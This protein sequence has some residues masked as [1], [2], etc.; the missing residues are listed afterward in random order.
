MSRANVEVVRRAFDA[1]E[2]GGFDATAEFTH[3]DF[4]MEQMPMHP[5]SGTYS[6]GEAARFSME[7][8]M[9]SFEGFESEPTEFIDAGERVVVVVEERGRA[10]GSGAE[11]GHAYGVVF[12]V[13]DGKIA[14]MEWFHSRAEAL[15]A[16]G[17]F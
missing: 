6:G 17:V 8:W 7:S 11:L 1:F 4:Q 13:R 2:S 15:E 16:A 3:P 12:T 9:G 5:E 14:R 10:R